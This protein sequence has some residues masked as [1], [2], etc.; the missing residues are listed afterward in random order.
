MKQFILPIWLVAAGYT[1]GQSGAACIASGGNLANTSATFSLANNPAF[2]T[3]K[4]EINLYGR[5]RF[6]GTVLAD[7]GICGHITLKGTAV[8]FRT[9][10][11]GTGKYNRQ[12]AEFCAG[13]KLSDKLSLG[14]AAGYQGISQWQDYGRSGGVTGRL[15]MYS[16]LNPKVNAAMVILN[17]WAG[18]STDLFLQRR[19]DISFG[20]SVNP[21]TDIHAHF[22]TLNGTGAVFGLSLDHRYKEKIRF[23]A[24]LQTGYEPLSAGI[25]FTQKNL[26]TGIA[27][28]YH[29]YLG[30]TPSFSLQ[31]FAK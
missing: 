29:T 23:L 24:S 26:C 21:I 1:F 14:F 16:T 30:F 28:A 10:W 11:S 19:A 2:S 4:K 20:Y 27:T 8:G 6:T 18:E 31:W 13:Q 7:G 12:T 3:T 17:P 5:N 15:G 25:F 9:A 22:R